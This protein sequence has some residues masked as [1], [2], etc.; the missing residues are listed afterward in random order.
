M[1]RAL[2]DEQTLGSNKTLPLMAAKDVCCRWC[3]DLCKS[4]DNRV[5]RGA[6]RDSRDAAGCGFEPRNLKPSHV[7]L[8]HSGK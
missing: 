4:D 3:E 5:V 6:K 7:I 8:V 2:S 1:S